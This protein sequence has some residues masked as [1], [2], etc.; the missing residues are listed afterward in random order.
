MKKLKKIAFISFGI[1]TGA[2]SA[3]TII[4]CGTNS[5]HNPKDTKITT[6]L[7]KTHLQKIVMKSF[8]NKLAN[9][10]A[11]LSDVTF[12]VGAINKTDKN[13]STVKIN[14]TAKIGTNAI[15]FQE[16]ISYNIDSNSYLYSSPK[17]S[18]STSII[19]KTKNPLDSAYTQN[20]PS[21]PKVYQNPQLYSAINKLVKT[22]LNNFKI[23]DFS[24]N[25]T[26]VILSNI[27]NTES[28][29][30]TG[31]L[32]SNDSNSPIPFK[33]KVIYD[34]LNKTYSATNFVQDQ[35]YAIK[36][37][38]DNLITPVAKSL[39]SEIKNGNSTTITNI[40]FSIDS[41]KIN[42]SI[43]DQPTIPVNGI[44]D[45]KDH[46]TIKFSEIIK[47]SYAAYD[48]NKYSFSNVDS[49]YSITQPFKLGMNKDTKKYINPNLYE[50]AINAFYT[51][52]Q[53]V[54]VSEMI[55]TS[56]VTFVD[57]NYSLNIASMT[58]DGVVKTKID[59]HGA[60]FTVKASYNYKTKKYQAKIIQ[61]GKSFE[62]LFTKANI[63]QE[64][65]SQLRLHYWSQNEDT[66]LADKGLIDF[67]YNLNN[68]T[69]PE[70]GFT[71]Y[72]PAITV[73]GHAITG[74]LNI[75]K[76]SFTL[77]YYYNAFPDEPGGVFIEDSPHVIG[78][79]ID[80]LD[81]NSIETQT[82]TW[83][84]EQNP[85]DTITNIVVTKSSTNINK[86]I[87]NNSISKNVTITYDDTTTSKIGINLSGKLSYSFTNKN[88]T[89][90]V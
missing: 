86:D 7:N 22:K 32:L 49:P 59:N 2:T 15:K 9:N 10:F 53:A 65:Q 45:L 5:N 50:S 74:N 17:I 77:I 11:N 48:N 56:K 36:L 82:A 33:V 58:F 47:Y 75:F 38:H 37:S 88:Y 43:L 84:K 70:D 64:I 69:F 24:T 71:I 31:H 81:T 66:T 83:L 39:Y 57:N 85:Q 72:D 6:L 21:G 13:S 90:T 44:Y 4:S 80:L 16:N 3:T 23:T 67:D 14:G 27:N 73:T 78:K 35:S 20:S 8:K 89:F 26:T 68:I 63:A 40:N 61:V 29:I 51:D 52:Y 54:N 28:T 12:T 79:P 55:A 87:T 18:Y 19:E 76:F 25:L 34:Y 62:Q 42:N 30:A 46:G 1:L 41:S 60:P